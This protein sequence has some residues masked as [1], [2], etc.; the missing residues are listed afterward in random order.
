MQK[1]LPYERNGINLDPI[2]GQ[3]QCIWP[4]TT[5]SV[6]DGALNY[7]DFCSQIVYGRVH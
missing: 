6:R 3:M 2:K 1:G 7:G 5:F 4:L